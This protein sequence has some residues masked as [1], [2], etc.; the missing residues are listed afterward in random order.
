ML[1]TYL[2]KNM[3]E[4]VFNH[5]LC[6]TDSQSSIAESVFEFEHQDFESEEEE[7]DSDK[8]FIDDDDSAEKTISGN[9]KYVVN[10]L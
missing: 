3:L 6:F 4:F 8:D 9:E 5:G 2:C 1:T 10:I 7:N